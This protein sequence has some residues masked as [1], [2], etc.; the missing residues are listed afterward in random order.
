MPASTNEMTIAGPANCAAACPVITKIPAP[1]MP[2]I[3]KVTRLIGPRARFR[4]CSP[5]S[6]DS[7]ISVSTD[8][9]ANNGLAI[10]L[11]LPGA[12]LRAITP[13]LS[14]NSVVGPDRCPLQENLTILRTQPGVPL[15]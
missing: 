4:Q 1:M 7:L 12:A 15:R 9:V 10:Q 8:F 2:P 6:P 3:P 5:V 14:Y 11:L 13:N